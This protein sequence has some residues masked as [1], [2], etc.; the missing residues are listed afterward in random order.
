MHQKIADCCPLLK[1]LTLHF[2]VTSGRGLDVYKDSFNYWLSHSRQAVERAF[3]MLT[4]RWGIFWRMFRFSFD[5]WSLVVMVCMKLHNLC[6]DRRV[7][8]PAQRFAE[9]VR[10]GDAWLVH[11]SAQDDDA[12]LRGRSSGERRREVTQQ[13]EQQ[14]CMRPV[15]ASMNSRCN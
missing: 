13:L 8:V 15:H 11:D 2:C 9:D 14:G 3:G 7:Q 10:E 12:L 4:Q 1:R 5:R 6:M